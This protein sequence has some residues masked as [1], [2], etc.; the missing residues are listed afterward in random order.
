MNKGQLDKEVAKKTGYSILDVAKVT[1]AFLN[2]I[3]ES[4][5][6]EEEVKIFAFGAFQIFKTKERIGRN[7]QTGEQLIIKSRL[8][9]R[10]KNS[11]KFF[12]KK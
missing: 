3:Q 10:F 1:H 2:S 8:K 11:P 4:L 9:T 5:Q 12:E 7:P 6:R